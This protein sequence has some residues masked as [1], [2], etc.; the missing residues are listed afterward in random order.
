MGPCPP[1]QVLPMGLLSSPPR[2]PTH[3]PT[4]QGVQDEAPGPG[5]PQGPPFKRRGPLAWGSQAQNGLGRTGVPTGVLREPEPLGP[6]AAS[7][8]PLRQ[9]QAL[10]A[11]RRAVGRGP[12]PPQW[13]WW[14]PGSAGAARALRAAAAG[15]AAVA[16]VKARARARAL[17]RSRAAA[18]AAVPCRRAEPRP[19]R[20]GSRLP[21][22][23]SVRH[24]I[25][26]APADVPPRTSDLHLSARPAG[27]RGT[28]APA[29]AWGNFS[30]STVRCGPAGRAGRGRVPP[31]TVPSLS[32]AS[33]GR[34]AAAAASKR[35]ESPEG[36]RAL[37]AATGP[38]TRSPEPERAPP[39]ALG[40]ASR[41]RV[42]GS[43][44]VPTPPGSR[45][46][47]MG[48]A[49]GGGISESAAR[50]AHGVSFL[51]VGAAFPARPHAGRR[52]QLRGVRVCERPQRRGGGGAA[53]WRRRGAPRAGQAGRWRDGVARDQGLWCQS[54]VPSPRPGDAE[55]TP[56][57][58]DSQSPSSV[59]E[60]GL[61]VLCGHGI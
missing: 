42:S 16:A 14:T 48:W 24:P 47:G 45:P 38:D 58:Q 15:G 32:P 59:Q 5:H 28:P 46:P 35:R 55:G 61:E 7:D 13:Y 19:P 10:V 21:D 29:A 17:R 6:L 49:W 56:S 39:R 60:C 36:E 44:R 31:L 37:G 9:L 11:G 34:A 23:S 25:H 50:G 22:P 3:T 33:S 1:L 30:P 2:M 57:D 54:C 20:P 53:R 43:A 27:G 51:L 18:G 8:R 41:P 26:A 12:P 52:G 4:S 40:W